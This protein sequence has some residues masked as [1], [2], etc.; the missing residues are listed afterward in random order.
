MMAFSRPL[1]LPAGAWQGTGFMHGDIVAQGVELMLFGM[2]TVVTFLGLLVVA[3]AGM[4]RLVGHYF[5]APEPATAPRRPGPPADA[6][7]ADDP[8][9]VAVISAAIRQHRQRHDK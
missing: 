5:P 9:L 1:T 6:T 2:G 7:A 4:S 3:T 8:Q